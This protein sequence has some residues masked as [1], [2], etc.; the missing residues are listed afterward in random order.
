MKKKIK[1]RMMWHLGMPLGFKR[2]SRSAYV[3]QYPIAEQ[4][5]GSRLEPTASIPANSSRKSILVIAIEVIL[6]PNLGRWY[7][8]VLWGRK[9]P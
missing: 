9:C 8:I 3:S 2:S 1:K 5:R 7:T 6:E 4:D